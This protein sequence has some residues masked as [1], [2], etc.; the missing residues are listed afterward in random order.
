MNN[1]D[2]VDALM[3]CTPEDLKAVVAALAA[4][5]PEKAY[6]LGMAVYDANP[7]KMVDGP[8]PGS[9]IGLAVMRVVGV[10]MADSHGRVKGIRFLR[11]KFQEMSLADAGRTFHE[12]G[13]GKPY[14]LPPARRAWVDMEAAAWR[15]AGFKVEIVPDGV[16]PPDQHEVCFRQEVAM[17]CTAD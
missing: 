11:T 14:E 12:I 9:P 5:N 16:Q 1:T 15:Y 10:E 17:I 3:L 13:A 4:A 8:P 6:D 7:T 2:I